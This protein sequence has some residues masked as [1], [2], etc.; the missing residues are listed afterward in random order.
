MIFLLY[1]TLPGLPFRNELVELIE[2]VSL[3]RRALG[4]VLFTTPQ[5]RGSGLYHYAL[6]LYHL[7]TA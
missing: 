3:E 5:G 4:W 7:T 6:I 1:Y 2:K